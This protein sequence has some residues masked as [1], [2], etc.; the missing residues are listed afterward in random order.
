LLKLKLNQRCRRTVANYT[1]VTISIPK[2]ATYIAAV[3]LTIL[4]I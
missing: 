2:H 1:V 3:L 4:N